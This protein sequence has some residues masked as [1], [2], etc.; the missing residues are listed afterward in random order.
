MTV[1]LFK[2]ESVK[3]AVS[4]GVLCAVAYFAVYIA[5]NTLGAIAPKTGFSEAFLGN[6]SSV[7]FICYAVGQLINGVVGDR[8]KARNMI[9]FGLLFAGIANLVFTLLAPVNETVSLV[10][11]GV[12]GFFLAMI[13]APMAK[14]VSEN[15]EPHHATRCSLG[16]TFS[17][18]FGSPAAGLI[19][20]SVTVWQISFYVS[21]IAMIGMAVV[22]FLCF[23]HFEK[24]GYVKYGQYQPPKEERAGGT[25]GILV[26]HGIIRF[27]IIAILTGVVRTTVVFWL[28]TYFNDYLGYSEDTS[29]LIFTVVTLIISLSAFL[30]VFVYELLG[31]RMLLTTALMF[32]ASALSFAATFLVP[33][34]LLR[35]VLITLSV[36]FS[37]A[38]ANVLWSVY[39]PSL[40]DT[41]RVSSATG[42][43]DFCS[44]IAAAASSRLF[45][46]A[47]TTIGWGPLTL[48][49]CALM[50]AGVFVTAIPFGKRKRA[51]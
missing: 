47:A 17:S 23:L 28:P 1:L 26:R 31:R 48:V 3:K 15:T 19:A 25:V 20:A 36:L 30:S 50:V 24:R 16:Y 11:Y 21:S 51:V 38:A 43:L 4:L 18:L 35:I 32:S 6:T 29:A 22:C 46:T 14:V 33:V 13:Y 10:A 44:Y 45:A 37:N 9:S 40:R 7:Y 2:N 41:G 49:W 12:T 27:A 42:F 8:I 34:P 39:C 5:R